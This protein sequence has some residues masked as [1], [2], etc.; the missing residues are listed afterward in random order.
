MTTR[1]PHLLLVDDD[2]RLVALLEDRLRRDGFEA[3]VAT[4][5]SQAISAIDRRWPD[6]VILDLM[7][8]DMRGEQVAAQIKKRADLPIIV[9]SAVTEVASRTASIRDFA[10]D[11]LVKPFHYSELRVRVERVLRRMPD[12]VPAEE[13]TVATGLVLALRRRE[14]VVHGKKIRLTPVECRLLGALVAAAGQPLTTEQLLGRVWAGADGADPV[15]VWV[16]IRRLRQKL[17]P[18]PSQPMFIHT[19]RGGGGYR[20]GDR[21]EDDEA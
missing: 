5:G 4:R 9:L 6:L 13:L 10:E 18:D 20:L 17:E 11:Y 8:P 21:A 15:Y 16:T 7:L 19:V 1:P 3:T 2:V 14:A 12:R